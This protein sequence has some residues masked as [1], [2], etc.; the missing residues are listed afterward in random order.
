MMQDKNEV[1]HQISTLLFIALTCG[2]LMFFFTRFFGPWALT[3]N[4][5][6]FF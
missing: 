2:V 6:A 1:Q 4:S 5:N 3:G